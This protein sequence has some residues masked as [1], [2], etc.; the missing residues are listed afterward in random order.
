VPGHNKPENR[1]ARAASNRFDGNAYWPSGAPS[2]RTVFVMMPGRPDQGKD[3]TTSR[4]E[5]WQQAGVA[6]DR[7]GMVADLERPTVLNPAAWLHGWQLAPGSQYVGRAVALPE[8]IPPILT[9]FFGRARPASGGDVGAH[10][11][12]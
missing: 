4:L 3:L 8:G 7:Q 11:H 5:E 6:F 12:E 9:D 1:W 2:P 10:Q